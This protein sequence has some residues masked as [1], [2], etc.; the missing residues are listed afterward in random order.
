MEWSGTYRDGKI[1]LNVPV[2]WKDGTKVV[3]ALDDAEFRGLREGDYPDTPEGREALIRDLESYPPPTPEE[4]ADFE[5][6]LADLRQWSRSGQ[7]AQRANGP[8][9]P[10][11]GVTDKTGPQS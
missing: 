2:D 3:V 11:P 6:S 7:T 8:A 4:A 9:A 1:E 5:A 10:P